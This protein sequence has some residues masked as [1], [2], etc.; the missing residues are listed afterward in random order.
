VAHGNPIGFP[1]TPRRLRLNSGS[2]V[3]KSADDQQ[4]D[5]VLARRVHWQIPDT[6]IL[7]RGAI[8]F[9]GF[10]DPPRLLFGLLK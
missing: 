4:P 1:S 7:Y 9:L 8:P 6:E 10:G 5:D 3:A 2:V